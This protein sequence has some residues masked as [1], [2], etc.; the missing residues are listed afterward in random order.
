MKSNPILEEVWRIKDEVA[1]DA[2]GDI[3][4]MCDNARKWVASH[5]HRGPVAR[6]AE[7]LRQMVSAAS[8]SGLQFSV[9]EESP[10]YTTTKK[11]KG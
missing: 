9:R 11:P 3:H 2:G 4:V 7:D 1:R 6:S 10:R 8:M 5:P